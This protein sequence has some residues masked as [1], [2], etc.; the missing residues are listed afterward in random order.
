MKNLLLFFFFLV[1]SG[2]GVRMSAVG[3]ASAITSFSGVNF[4][5]VHI[6]NKTNKDC[7]VEG[8]DKNFPLPYGQEA[9][10]TTTTSSSYR[11]LCDGKRVEGVITGLKSGD[12]F[13]EIECSRWRGCR[14][15]EDHSR[16]I[17]EKGLQIWRGSGLSGWHQKESVWSGH[18]CFGGGCDGGSTLQ[19]RYYEQEKRHRDWVDRTTQPR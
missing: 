17:K 14:V 12:N 1:L 3:Q 10:F 2:C 6:W 5:Q 4:A 7:K 16:F 8:S 13:F 18:R 15:T 19:K 11:I 9:S